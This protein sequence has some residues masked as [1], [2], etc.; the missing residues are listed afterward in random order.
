MTKVTA[1]AVT[2]GIWFASISS[3]AALT[4]V[5]S[6]PVVP[7]DRPEES[8]ASKSERAPVAVEYRPAAPPAILA[9][10]GRGSLDRRK[11]AD[12][13]VWMQPPPRHRDISEMRCSGW[14]PLASGPVDQG[15]RYCE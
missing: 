3:A 1:T 13:A 14:K 12:R 15:V 9:M 11:H 6:C 10:D 2:I 5:L 7:P 8:T 4:Y